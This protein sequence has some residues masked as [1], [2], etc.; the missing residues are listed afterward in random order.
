MDNRK[1][2]SPKTQL[3]FSGMNCT[4]ESLVGCGS[5]AIVYQ[6]FYPDQQLKEMKHRVLIKELFPYHMQN[7]IYRDDKNDICWDADASETVNLHR[8]SFNRGN[9]VHLKLLE[10]YPWEI[11]TN[12]NTFHLHNTL[13]TVLGYSGGR[14]LDKDLDSQKEIPLTLHV[15]RML[16]LLIVL[17]AFHKSEFLHLDISPENIL[18]IGDG[19]KERV[20]LID[21]N[22]VHTLQEIKEGNNVY[23]SE[24]EGYTAPEVHMGNLNHIGFS[25][26]L[27]AL[28]AVFYRCIT[29]KKLSA[30]Q[31]VR[32]EVP[33][34]SD[35]ACLKNLPET[36]ISKIKQILKKGLFVRF[37][38]RYQNV[39]QMRLDLEEL[40]DR[41]DGKGI[42]HWALWETGHIN[43]IHAIKI[44]PALDYIKEEEKIY[45]IAGTKEDGTT[46]SF[47]EMVKDITSP[48][49]TSVLL[50]GSG[51]MGKTTTL[52]R[53]AYL[54][55]ADYLPSEPA[56]TYISLYGWRNS[57]DSF[58]KNRILE[59]LKFKPQTDSM[60]TARHELMHLLSSP[61]RTKWGDCPKII[62][63]LDGFN[64]AVG[65][66]TPLIKEIMELSKLDGVRLLLT[67]RSQVENFPFLKIFLKPLE[68]TQVLDVLSENGLLPPENATLFQLLRTPIIISIFIK[69]SQNEEKQLFIHSQ[70]E[71]LEHYLNAMLEK[72]T[73]DL[74]EDSAQRWSIEAAL[75][76][77]LPA[78][79]KLI[80]SKGTAVLDKMLL[81]T[82]KTCYR[83]LSKHRITTIFPQWIGHLS[84]IR[85]D[86]QT[87]E[88][89]YGYIVQ[90]ILWRRLGL[91]LRDEQGAYRIVH[92]VIEAY[93]LHLE[94]AFAWKWMR[95]TIFHSS[96]ATI[97]TMAFTVAIYKGI[98]MPYIAPM[99]TEETK[100]CYDSTLSESVLNSAFIAYINAANQYENL[101]HLLEAF[102]GETI[103]ETTYE[104]YLNRCLRDLEE[105]QKD[106]SPL[107]LAY[108]E[109]LL[110]SGE[111]MPWSR[112]EWNMELYQ[113]LIV[114]PAERAENYLLYINLLG[115]LKTD[116]SGWEYY[117]KD[118]INQFSNAVE[119][120][121]YL[122]GKY[123]QLLLK[124]ELDTME[125]SNVEKDLQIY[126]LYMIDIALCPNQDKITEDATQTLESYQTQQKDA[127]NKFLQSGA[128]TLFGSGK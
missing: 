90:K 120:D 41:I 108:A 84:E 118:Y 111:V 70:E 32:S 1:P 96:M 2:L 99:L 62:I 83:R 101:L 74:P 77:V 25:S 53:I 69:T 33:D 115:Q 17:E 105:N 102:E 24:K 81:P 39:Q 14:S 109:Q 10:K 38:Q 82:V 40:Q 68:E 6:G 15:R 65:D 98:Y 97:V 48:D 8:L 16:E 85:A 50:L 52:L 63:L 95:Q 93:L 112:Q 55:K 47:Q 13:Y 9:E 57:D 22:S 79:A 78:I 31:T 21:Y 12:L 5:N 20:T 3:P 37:S 86:T 49:G 64:E 104:I 89:W 117:G 34:L 60:E 113:S 128:V 110:T 123:Y 91:I 18:L 119:R 107:A 92:Q 66:L 56:V 51:G 114:L 19:K 100:I 59:N 127:W 7:A 23:Y 121:A 54:Q 106:S 30:M 116:A 72:E 126:H 43:I 46:V 88:E 44:N 61:L 42:T 87:A 45:P 76:Y 94:K 103:D 26:D 11:D 75:F 124:P 125:K 28:T 80:H 71:L 36:V 29:G 27:Y 58:I 4:I 67:S 73:K 122:L 35:A